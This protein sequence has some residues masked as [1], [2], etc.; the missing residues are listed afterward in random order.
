MADDICQG[1]PAKIGMAVTSIFEE[2]LKQVIPGWEDFLT[3]ARTD[4]SPE[5]L[6][7]IQ[8]KEDTAEY[9]QTYYATR[10]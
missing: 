7:L 10:D 6:T 3:A 8:L 5:Y 9:M 1:N 4:N 2:G